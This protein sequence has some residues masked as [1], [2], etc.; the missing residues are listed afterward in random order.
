MKYCGNRMRNCV[1]W[2]LRR[3]EEKEEVEEEE[4]DNND[5]WTLAVKF[6]IIWSE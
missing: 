3:A 5:N 6:E 1:S 4:E 2:S